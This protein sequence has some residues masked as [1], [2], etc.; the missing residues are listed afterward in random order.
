[1]A[2]KLWHVSDDSGAMVTSEITE[3]P[4][5]R[6][7]L[8]DSDSYILELYNAVYIWQGK[9]SSTKE[10]YA[11]MKIAKDFVRNNNKPAGTSVSRLPQGTEDSTFKSFFDGFYAHIKEDFGDG[12]QTS[13]AAQDMSGVAAQQVKAKELMFDK[14]GPLDQVTKTVYFVEADFHTLTPITDER[15]QGKFFA[16]SCYVVHL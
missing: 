15:E 16:E 10:K 12:P 3:R 8:I 9:S 1:M 7:H 11:G 14:L 6:A 4:L 13:S 5:T 2:Y